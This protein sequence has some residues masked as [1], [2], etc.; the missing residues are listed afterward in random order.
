MGPTTQDEIFQI[1]A[2][3]ILSHAF[4]QQARK[5]HR[6][7]TDSAVFANRRRET[8]QPFERARRQGDQSPFRP[9]RIRRST[10]AGRHTQTRRN[11][12]KQLQSPEVAARGRHLATS[13]RAEA[14][15]DFVY[16]Q[17][18]LHDLARLEAPDREVFVAYDETDLTLTRLAPHAP[19]EPTHLLEVPR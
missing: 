7:N 10:P 5:L 14:L 11:V 9:A 6:L 19:A 13:V 4:E 8:F 18:G 12:D 2:G 17:P 3:K 1:R 15:R 16:V